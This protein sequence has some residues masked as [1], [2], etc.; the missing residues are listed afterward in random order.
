MKIAADMIFI[1]SFFVLG[2]DFW[3]KLH[4]LFVREARVR[5]N[6]R[7]GGASSADNLNDP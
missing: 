1:A 4:A 3:D 5:M 7:A 6:N 2:G